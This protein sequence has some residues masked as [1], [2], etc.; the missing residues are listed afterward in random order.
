MKKRHLTCRECEGMLG[1]LGPVNTATD[2]RHEICRSLNSADWRALRPFF[3]G[4]LTGVQ[5]GGA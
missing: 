3:L 1:P 5:M 2:G 4:N